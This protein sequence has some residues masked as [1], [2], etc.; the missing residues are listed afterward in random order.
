[1]VNYNLTQ[2]TA[3][4]DDPAHLKHMAQVTA[5][6]QTVYDGKIENLRFFIQDFNRRI[7]NKGLYHEFS[8]RTNENPRLQGIREEDWNFDHLLCWRHANFIKNFNSV[9]I[10]QLLQEKERIK[11][12]LEML[13][14]LP[15][16][17]QDDGANEL[18]SK[19]HCVGF[20][21][22]SG[23]AGWRWLHQK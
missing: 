6:L 15:E 2:F 12:T 17:A 20:L 18:A 11:D 9:M 5:P 1:M 8:I 7:Q 19:Q 22:S 14:N 23:I 10:D 13:S 3:A 21:N 4:I 16:T